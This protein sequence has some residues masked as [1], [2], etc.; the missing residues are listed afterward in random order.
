ML[1]EDTDRLC[2]VHKT[3]LV[4]GQVPILYGLIRYGDV[5]REQHSA[6]FPNSKFLV[7]GGCMVGDEYFYTAWYCPACRERHKTWASENNCNDGLAPTE[8][9]HNEYIAYVAR[10]M[11]VPKSIPDEVHEFVASGKIAKA[12]KLLKEKNPNHEFSLLRGFVNMLV[13]KSRK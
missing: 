2:E 12:I 4:A 1:I 10:R 5:F 3:D 7:F 8:D 6:Y 13:K 9:E 11:G